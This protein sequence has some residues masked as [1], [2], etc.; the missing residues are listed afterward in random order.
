MG[1]KWKLTLWRYQLAKWLKRSG[2]WK[3]FRWKNFVILMILKL[4]FVGVYF[5]FKWNF[6]CSNIPIQ[7]VVSELSL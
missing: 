1:L 4:F 7:N 6:V 3:R 5:L 2:L